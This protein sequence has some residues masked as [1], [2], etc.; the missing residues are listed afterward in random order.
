[1]PYYSLTKD[2]IIVAA[3]LADPGEVGRLLGAFAKDAE[4]DR[5]KESAMTLGAIF[6]QQ[7]SPCLLCDAQVCRGVLRRCN[8][9]PA[10][11]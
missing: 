6:R 2:G 7:P 11:V 3:S 4:T 8:G 5:E 10:A 1:M 9:R